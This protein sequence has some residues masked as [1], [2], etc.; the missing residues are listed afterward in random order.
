MIFPK[1]QKERENGEIEFG[2]VSASICLNSAMFS[3][4]NFVVLK[5]PLIPVAMKA[6]FYLPV[7]VLHFV[8]SNVFCQ[9]L[10]KL[11]RP[12]FWKF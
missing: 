9:E 3:A 11:F 6:I 8:F 2:K 7:V 10:R 4:T 1:I 5:H 12:G